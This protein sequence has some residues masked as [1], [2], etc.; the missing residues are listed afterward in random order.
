[1]YVNMLKTSLQTLAVLVLAV[2]YVAS[3]VEFDAIH[4][5]LHDHSDHITHTV[6]DEQDPCHIA[7]YHHSEKGCGHK[8]H[9]TVEK[10]CPLCHVHSSNEKILTA[11]LTF[12]QTPVSNKFQPE[13]TVSA[14]VT[15]AY[16]L[17][18]RAPPAAA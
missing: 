15:R 14:I 4:H 6:T 17:P 3:N 10:K 7:L 1:M 13:I 16:H 8:A 2:I 9:L 5:E 12:I 11:G 18:S